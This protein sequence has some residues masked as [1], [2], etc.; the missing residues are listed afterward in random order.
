M[1]NSNGAVALGRRLVLLRKAKGWTQEVLAHEA[2]V[3][4]AT[5][6]RIEQATVSPSVDALISISRALGIHLYYLVQDDAITGSEESP[7]SDQPRS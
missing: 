4:L 5:I 7:R 6:K 2:D 1:K 3:G